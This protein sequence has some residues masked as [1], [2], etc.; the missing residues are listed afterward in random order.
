MEPK[1][2]FD[3]LSSADSGVTSPPHRMSSLGLAC[4]PRESDGPQGL[5]GL[6]GSQA[7]VGDE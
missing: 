3:H 5:L 7:H 4:A 2:E 1:S 6:G